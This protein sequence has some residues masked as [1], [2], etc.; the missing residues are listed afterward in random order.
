M[1]FPANVSKPGVLRPHLLRSWTSRAERFIKHLDQGIAIV[2]V[3]LP[4]VELH[5]LL[6][7]FSDRSFGLALIWDCQVAGF[8]IRLEECLFNRICYLVGRLV[9][10]KVRRCTWRSHA[11][12]DLILDN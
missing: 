4:L 2:G 11:S 7:L 9:H 10:G 8:W 6:D 3:R 1:G 12:L 5:K